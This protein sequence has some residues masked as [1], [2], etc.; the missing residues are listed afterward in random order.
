MFGT[1]PGVGM[2]IAGGQGSDHF[3]ITPH[4]SEPLVVDAD[5]GR[6][7]SGPIVHAVTAGADYMGL[8]LEGI[9]AQVCVCVCWCARAMRGASEG[10]SANA[11]THG[12]SMGSGCVVSLSAFKCALYHP[13]RLRL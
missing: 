7:H 6:G 4:T 13:R 3:Y 2:T 11:S 8:A 9:T 5:E 12:A 10:S 1:K